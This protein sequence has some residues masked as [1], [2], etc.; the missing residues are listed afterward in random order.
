MML[1]IQLV[2]TIPRKAVNPR[3]SLVFHKRPLYNNKS[4]LN[5]LELCFPPL[6]VIGPNYRNELV[7]NFP[8][9][10]KKYR[11]IGYSIPS[12]HVTPIG[13]QQATQFSER[14]S[15]AANLYDGWFSRNVENLDLAPSSS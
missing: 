13:T 15:N 14:L 11:Y 12:T 9:D 5:S 1:P 10:N 3:C 7:K 4:R 2:S 8:E 6:S